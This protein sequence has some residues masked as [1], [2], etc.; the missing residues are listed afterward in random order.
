[1]NVMLTFSFVC[2]RERGVGFRGVY[3]FDGQYRWMPLFFVYSCLFLQLYHLIGTFF[4]SQSY[5][6]VFCLFCFV[7]V[8]PGFTHSVFCNLS[9]MLTLANGKAVNAFLS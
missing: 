5:L 2:E 7:P 4:F 6:F 8:F 1:M 9:A 3:R